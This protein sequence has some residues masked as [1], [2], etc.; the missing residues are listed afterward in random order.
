MPHDGGMNRLDISAPVGSATR[1]RIDVRSALSEV[2]INQCQQWLGEEHFLGPAKTAGQRLFQ[3]VYED[4]QPVAVLLWAASAWHLKDRD[5]WI[6]W[7]P[8]TRARRLKLIVSNWRFLIL[9]DTRRPNLA[10]QCLAAALRVLQDQWQVLYHYCPV[11]A[12]SFTGPESHAG[13]CYKASGWQPLGFSKGFERHHCEFYVPNDR[14]KKLWVK[15]LQPDAREILIAKS[16]PESHASAETDG[17][18][19]RSPL[20]AKELRTLSEVFRQIPEP[21][22]RANMRYPLP[23]VLSII[24]IALL[25]G[26]IHISELLRAGQRLSQQQREQIGLR[27]KHGSKFRPAPSYSVYR[28][29]LGKLDVIKMSQIFNTWLDEHNGILPRSL[30]MDGKTIVHQLGKM[31]S[32][33]DQKDGVPVAMVC[34]DEGKELPASQALLASGE[35]CLINQVVTA[36]ALHCQSESAREIVTGGGDYLFR[37]KDNQ[38]TLHKRAETLLDGQR[39]PFFQK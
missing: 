39:P 11:L 38:P 10:S 1:P 3:L 23:G 30:A 24:S 32:L 28:D 7:D 22:P 17:T 5:D 36:D 6:G 31:V 18:G 27:R 34:N 21:R 35:V 2:D 13:T 29:L 9:E 16:L 19:V 33:V 8:L 4:D 15:E 25:G 37:I 12:E 20:K 14:P 26:A